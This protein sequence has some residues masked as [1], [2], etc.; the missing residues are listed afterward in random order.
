MGSDEQESTMVMGEYRIDLKPMCPTQRLIST[1][2]LRM[3]SNKIR[4]VELIVA[5]KGKN[6]LLDA[7]RCLCS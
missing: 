1:N 6:N 5:I 7:Q 3:L 4:I 2:S